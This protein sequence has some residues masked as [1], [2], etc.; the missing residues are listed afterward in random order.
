MYEGIKKAGTSI[1]ITSLTNTIAFFLG[2]LSSLEALSS[3][4]MFAGL[5]IIGLYFTSMTLFT[6][7]MVWDIARQVERK[8]DC[9]GACCCSETFCCGGYFL[10]KK[11]KSFP[12][13]DEVEQVDPTIA[14]E[15]FSSGTEKFLYEKYSAALLSDTGRRLVITVWVLFAVV[16]AWGCS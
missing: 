9:C 11:Q 5:G 14:E 16:C 6:A 4:C 1:T 15:K 12:F 7:F 8:G 3:F 2:C 13:V 10:T